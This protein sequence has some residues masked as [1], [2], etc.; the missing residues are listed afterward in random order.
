MVSQ[1]V[2][3]KVFDCEQLICFSLDTGRKSIKRFWNVCQ[4]LCSCLFY[5]YN[6][7]HVNI[8]DSDT[9]FGETGSLI[10]PFSFVALQTQSQSHNL[11]L[12]NLV[13]I[14]SFLKFNIPGYT[15][16]TVQFGFILKWIIG[17][18]IKQINFAVFFFSKTD[19]WP[20]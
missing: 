8:Q 9:K 17:H 5:M 10:F 16:F 13:C 3:V 1:I 19:G 11:V 18:S 14:K 15:S 2:C 12:V 6:V 4:L 7:H 20:V